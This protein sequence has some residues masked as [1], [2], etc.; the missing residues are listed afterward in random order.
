MGTGFIILISKKDININIKFYSYL[1]G[2][3]ISDM[4]MT[5]FLD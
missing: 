5:V 3:I 2:V 1:L 4:F